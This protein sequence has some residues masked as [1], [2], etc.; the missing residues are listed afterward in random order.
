MKVWQRVE[1]LLIPEINKARD[2]RLQS[3]GN[4]RYLGRR[5]LVLDQ[6]ANFIG[7]IPP[8]LLAFSPSFTEFVCGN[9]AL[10][11]AIALENDSDSSALNEQTR[12]ALNRMMPELESLKLERAS[13]L[14][15]L[16]P[17]DDAYEGVT[18][19]GVLALATSVYECVPC[20]QKASGLHMLAHHCYGSQRSRSQCPK[21][22]KEGKETVQALLEL[23][24]L[25]KETTALELDRRDDRFVCSQ[26][27]LAIFLAVEARPPRRLARDWRSCVRLFLVVCA[28]SLTPYSPQITH[29]CIKSNG[30]KTSKWLL[31]E[32][33]ETVGLSWGGD[34]V[35]GAY[36]C[37]RCP[38]RVDRRYGFIEWQG[39]EA[40]KEHLK[41]ELVH[42]QCHESN[43]VF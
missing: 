3:A 43:P 40:V 30:A 41:K 18:E 2:S 12:D 38:P 24:G 21:F 36:A 7:T 33:R 13:L 14:R 10:A 5:G 17:R 34:P 39:L 9:R 23:I 19:E 6:F 35:Y 20:H 25:G 27:P 37:M 4:E 28:L 8:L 11:D 26:C 16:L 31:V 22:S 32:K 15:S 1:P 42:C 29:T